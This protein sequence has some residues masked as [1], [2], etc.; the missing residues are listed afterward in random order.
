MPESFKTANIEHAK[1]MLKSKDV[2][3]VDI[4]DPES[5]K[6]DHIEGA[7]LLNKENIK[8]FIE[9]TD[10]TKVVLCYCYRGFSSQEA[11]RFL[12]QNGFKEVYNLQ[13]GF[14]AWRAES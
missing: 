13:G 11:S 4:R 5:F 14:E 6:E 1:Q 3:V 9:K 2:T 8:E 10:K 7:I 12:L